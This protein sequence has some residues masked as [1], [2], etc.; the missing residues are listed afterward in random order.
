M[1]VV[2]LVHLAD[3][4]Q[5]PLRDMFHQLVLAEVGDIFDHVNTP[6]D[7]KM[8]TFGVWSSTISRVRNDSA[9]RSV[10][11][12]VRLCY[13]LPC[14][15]AHRRGARSDRDENVIK[16]K[17]WIDSDAA[18]IKIQPKFFRHV[19]SSSSLPQNVVNCVFEFT[20]DDDVGG[21][22]TFVDVFVE[23][24]VLQLRW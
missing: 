10:A 23:N 18:R 3:D 24:N 6:Q 8:E 16:H 19:E 2:N 12:S 20:V 21:H 17:R 13:V 7:A 9:Q 15:T 11:L 1:N 22:S 4:S 14:H 5:W